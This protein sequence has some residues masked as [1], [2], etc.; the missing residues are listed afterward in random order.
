MLTGPALLWASMSSQCQLT[1]SSLAR[2]SYSWPCTPRRA[3][4]LPCGNH[5]QGCRKLC[6]N[7]AVTCGLFSSRLY[8][9][10]CPCRGCRGS[11]LCS[12]SCTVAPSP[13]SRR[14]ASSALVRTEFSSNSTQPAGSQA[15]AAARL[16]SKPVGLPQR[17]GQ[18]RVGIKAA[19]L[20]GISGRRGSA[21]AAGIHRGCSGIARV[22]DKHSR[23]DVALTCST[24]GRLT[25]ETH[26]A[27]PCKVAAT[28][29]LQK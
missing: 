12:V 18:G 11:A 13:G 5:A 10:D 28:P 24:S 16:D 20:H 6:G 8:A 7:P 15:V 27:L 25:E 22:K 9:Q 17:G 14:T 21:S 3:H 1:L 29:L 26:A 19:R 23:L 2:V 4:C